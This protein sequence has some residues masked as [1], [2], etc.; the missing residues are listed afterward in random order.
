M[1]SGL[2]AGVLIG[3]GIDSL[4]GTFPWFMLG[5]GLVGLASGAFKFV[6]EAMAINREAAQRYRSTHPRTAD[7]QGQP[8]T[9]SRPI[10][11]AKK[12]DPGESPGP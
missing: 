1:A 12:H 6:R 10:A 7:D 4:A 5:L 2:L 11:D 8:G 3:W 9:E